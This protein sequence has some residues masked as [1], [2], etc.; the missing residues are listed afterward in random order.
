VAVAGPGRDTKFTPERR[1]SIL[2]DL[3]AGLTRVCASER[4][5]IADRTLRRWLAKASND[6]AMASFL[7]AIKKAERDA[8]AK[9][10]R[11]I[12]AACEGGQVLD[13]KTT[14][15][16]KRDGTTE[17][18]VT[19]KYSQGQWQA[20]AWWLERKFPESWGKDA[21]LLREVIAEYRK[22]KGRGGSHV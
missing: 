18:E 15:H 5:G 10:V 6:P 13:R 9:N 14:T 4:A 19:E 8:E 16:T 22:N 20:A 1:A 12:L 3:A 11:I 2:A 17:T 7:S 21:E